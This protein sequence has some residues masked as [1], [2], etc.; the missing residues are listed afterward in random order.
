[1]RTTRLAAL[2]ALATVAL[3]VGACGK[4]GTPAPSGGGNASEAAGTGDKCASSGTAFGPATGVAIT[5]SPTFDKIKTGGKVVVGVKFDQPNL[6][7]KDADGK[8]CGFDIEM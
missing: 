3:A 4:A 5:G 2:A 1:M 6:G 8:R 7:Y